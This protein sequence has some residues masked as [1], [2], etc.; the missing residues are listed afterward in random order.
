MARASIGRWGH[1]VA[2][3]E[4]GDPKEHRKRGSHERG[5]G[6]QETGD[7]GQGAIIEL[8]LPDSVEDDPFPDETFRFA[9]V[10]ALK[11]AYTSG[12]K[13]DY[14]EVSVDGNSFAE[15]YADL[16]AANAKRVNWKAYYPSIP[17]KYFKEHWYIE[18]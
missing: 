13:L 2:R 6:H 12:V 18:Y 8:S 10:Q 3:R 15:F 4:V 16:G 9:A 14:V 7:D 1:T 17:D 11:A 5:T